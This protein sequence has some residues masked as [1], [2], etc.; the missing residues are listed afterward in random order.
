MKIAFE[1]I[2]KELVSVSSV[3]DYKT[4]LV[5]LID[6]INNS[7]AVI[8]TRNNRYYGVVDRQAIGRSR[9]LTV[10]ENLP[11]GKIAVKTAVVSPD[12]SINGVIKEFNSSTATAL[13]YIDKGRV[14]GILKRSSILK[15]ILSLHILEGR[16]VFD[17]ISVP[18]FVIEQ[19]ESVRRAKDLMDQY[20]VRKLPVAT[21][22]GEICGILRYSDILNFGMKGES[23]PSK[24]NRGTVSLQDTKAGYIASQDFRTIS[25]DADLEAAMRDFI[26]NRKG[27]IIAV[28]GGKPVGILTIGNI[29]N[30]AAKEISANDYNV[31]L[32]GLDDYTKEY[33]SDLLREM[34][35]I[36]EKIDKF[37][38][39][40]VSYIH[41]NVKRIK[42]KGYELK[43]M[44][45]LT[46]KGVI[47]IHVEDYNLDTTLQR[48]EKLIY[49]RIKNQK[50]IIITNRERD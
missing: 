48:L 37:S 34:N 41:L 10:S 50:E 16:K 32:S 9:R 44:V 5:K 26:N 24:S 11:V 14:Q 36:A 15:A 46:S 40:K 29:F 23:R 19:N 6:R 43:A 2:P 21:E 4:P 42:S 33:E 27:T 49:N 17:A 8:I 1:T 25:T 12:T 28:K 30:L 35:K 3:F 22:K 39:I 45:G 7:G 20:K 31:M 13:P 38:G 47:T 18:I